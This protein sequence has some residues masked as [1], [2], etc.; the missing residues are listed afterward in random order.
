MTGVATA[1]ESGS[2]SKNLAKI[3]FTK[4]HEKFNVLSTELSTLMTLILHVDMRL[5]TVAEIKRLVQ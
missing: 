5:T 1:L 2:N 3:T 4:K